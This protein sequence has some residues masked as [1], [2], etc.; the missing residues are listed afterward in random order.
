[1]SKKIILSAI[2][3][4]LILFGLDTRLETTVYHYSNPKIPS[5]FD[6][7]RIVQI[8]DFHLK[9][10]GKKEDIL[11]SAIEK[12][13][14]DTIVITGDLI[15]ENHQD[16]SPLED[17]LL[18]IHTLAP[19]YYVSGN[20]EFDP[21]TAVQYQ[22]MLS[23]F[24]KYGITN[25]DDSQTFLCKNEEKICLT[26]SMWRSDLVGEY[27]PVANQEYFN[28]LLYH[29]SNYFSLLSNFGYDLL[30]SGHIHGGIIR[31]PFFGGLFSNEGNL[32][33]E[34]DAGVF[35]SGSFTMISLRG[36]GDSR[37]PRFYNRP[38][39]VCVTLHS[40]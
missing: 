34:Y 2:V 17:L 39:L 20:H 18:G 15:D 32:F 37:V 31:I 14:P 30:L 3:L 21:G 28:I 7:F 4:L 1:M 5:S 25:L 33:P 38:E 10:F 22:T 23:L 36:L 6:G 13:Q 24:E 9:E 29:G 12:C 40:R 26:G 27:L 16:L 8:S 19:V 35:T 11:I